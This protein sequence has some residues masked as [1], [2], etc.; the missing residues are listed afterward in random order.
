MT[1]V[2][3]DDLGTYDYFRRL[4]G[5]LGLVAEFETVW[6]EPLDEFELDVSESIVIEKVLDEADSEYILIVSER[7]PA[8]RVLQPQQSES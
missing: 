1:L 2:D 4:I 5:D 6:D 3:Y 8:Y 7:P